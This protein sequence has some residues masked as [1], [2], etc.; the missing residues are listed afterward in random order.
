[1]TLGVGAL[2]ALTLTWIGS[3]VATGATFKALAEAFLGEQP[4]WKR[5]L[6]YAGRRICTRSCG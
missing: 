2:L 3:L 5:S 1:M 4:D 6:A